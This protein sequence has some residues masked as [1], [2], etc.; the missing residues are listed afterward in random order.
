MLKNTT[1]KTFPVEQ[2]DACEPARAAGNDLIWFESDRASLAALVIGEIRSNSSHS[3]V[4]RGKRKLP[5]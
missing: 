4:N 3:S 1:G 2:T 5:H